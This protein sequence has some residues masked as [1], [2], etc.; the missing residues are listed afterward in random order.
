M[1][2]LARLAAQLTT[3]LLPH[4]Y[5]TL[6]DPVLAGS[7]FRAR[8]RSIQPE[9]VGS[10]SVEFEVPKSF[11]SHTAGQ[12][13]RLGVDI[14][15]VR[16]WR[17]YSITTPQGS[18]S[19]RVLSITVKETSNGLM[20]GHLVRNAR[21]GD[22]VFLEPAAGEFVLSQEPTELIFLAFGSGITPIMSMIRTLA[23]RG[24][25][26]A[27]VLLI[28]GARTEDEV[29]FGEELAALADNEPWLDLVL[30][31]SAARGRF[32]VAR[33]DQLAPNWRDAQTYVS[34]PSAILDQ[35]VD[36]WAAAGLTEQLFVE[37]FV[38]PLAHVDGAGG[39]VRFSRAGKSTAVDGSTTL[40]DAGE[41]AGI[42]MP[43]GCRMGIC[44][45][46]VVPLKS[47]Q[48]R[49]MRTGE[50]HGEPGDIIQTCVNAAAC[51]IEIDV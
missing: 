12:Y 20:S 48:V 50:V 3:P 36:L 16:H 34:G 38:T 41:A 46:C 11:P 15:G 6:V 42:L 4:D 1:N 24:G 33:L 35:A 21:A 17:S 7:G 2:Q 22:L 5:L 8:I 31:E 26:P 44:H 30:W 29:I 49:D 18:T 23:A 39:E 10:C 32:D 9:T 45:T 14:A 19:R 43:N 51:D 47:G 27:P 37:R 25:S 13:L 40:L 28:V